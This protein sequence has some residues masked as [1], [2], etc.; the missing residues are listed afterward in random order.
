MIRSLFLSLIFSQSAFA[1]DT[2]LVRETGPLTPEEELKML[3]VPDGFEVKLFAS[4][5]W[6]NKPINLAFDEKGRLWVS[7]SFEYPYA[8]P[9]ERWSDPEGTRVK[10]SR[11]GIFILEDTDGDGRADKKT[12]FADQL[13][14]P[15]GVLP[16]KNGCI[17]WSIP[18]LWFFEDTDGDN[19]CDKRTIL[20]GPLGW[21]K[22]VH[23]NVSSLRMGPDGWVY[24]THGFSNTSHF[25]V[26]PENLRGAKPG[27]PGTTLDLHSGNVFRFKPDGSRIELFTAGQVN[28][29][30]IAIDRLGNLY[31]ADCHSA[32]IYQLLPGAVYPSFGK[33]HDGLG[34]GPVMIQHNHSSTGICGITYL[35]NNIWGPEWNDH[36][37]IG[38]VV[39]SRINT[40]RLTFT[41]S[42]PTATEKPD[43]LS[44]DDPWF[45]PVDLRFGPD[46]ALYVA[47]FYNKIIGHYEVP[48]THPERDKER[49]RIWKII[50]KGTTKLPAPETGPIA[51]MRWKA[52]A[53]NLDDADLTTLAAWLKTGSPFEKRAAAEALF[54]PVSLDWIPHL[55]EALKSTPP[56]DLSLRHQLR[57]TL[58]AHLK[59][60]GAIAYLT[61]LPRSDS[62]ADLVS[63]INAIQSP[64]AADYLIASIR[65]NPGDPEELAKTLTQIASVKPVD[66]LI[67]V[68]QEKFP[69]D[70]SI[71][72]RLLRAIVDGVQQRG[73]LPGPSIHQWGNRLAE[74][75][76]TAPNPNF[77]QLTFLAELLKYAAP[78]GLR[79]QLA[80]F[81]PAPPPPPPSPFGPEQQA[82]K[83]KL[84]AA[85]TA[86]FE[87]AK[88]VAADGE[89]VFTT[90][91]AMCHAIGGKGALIGPQ[92]DGIGNRGAARLIEDILDPS[93][94]VDSHF[95]LHVIEKKDGSTFAGLERGEAGKLLICVD[96]A[97]KEHRIP[98]SEIV[99]NEEMGLSLMPAAFDQT[100]PEKD[101]HA[102]IAWLLTL[103]AT[104]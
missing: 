53:G 11:D 63:I 5:P 88:P 84:I 1:L 14:I 7:S 76:L 21:E 52:R 24:A 43:F 85:R 81:L 40:D 18:N 2:S 12:V 20:F 93:R 17:A 56:D 77:E 51:E 61:T 102:L 31:T 6:I 65:Q 68:V 62:E 103:S 39:T 47:D 30:G 59:M 45:R 60:P 82:E 22:D 41:G 28:P 49:G 86:S 87:K 16:Y 38:N 37:L 78:T 94:N 92:L 15:T 101:F 10:D 89:P 67:A 4:E 95:R 54:K 72:T 71:Q 33:P 70:L 64:E 8:A 19:V 100:I 104:K 23:G 96:A 66:P 57:I 80:K 97:G 55:I 75:H 9:K 35:E 48:L 58:R 44:S 32:P 42:T 99:K 74:K 79:D 98:K 26:R 25:K 29:F 13:N 91:C 83:D 73:D 46:G 36:I 27:D 3:Q 90:H 50:K 34:F 69:T